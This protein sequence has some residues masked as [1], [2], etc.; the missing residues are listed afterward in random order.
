MSVEQQLLGYQVI[1]HVQAKPL[2]RPID[3]WRITK[4]SV[5]HKVPCLFEE[6]NYIKNQIHYLV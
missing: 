5:L 1:K 2:Q 4:L 6:L 3:A